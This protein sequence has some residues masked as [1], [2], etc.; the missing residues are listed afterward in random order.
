MQFSALE[1]LSHKKDS[2]ITGK[3]RHIV[4]LQIYFVINHEK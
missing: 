3:I 4:N 1:E 2:Q